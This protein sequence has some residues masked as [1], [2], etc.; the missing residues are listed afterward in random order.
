MTDAEPKG[1]LAA[2]LS[3]FGIALGG[4]AEVGVDLPYRQ[5]DDF[6]SAAE[7]S[8]YRV[9]L[10]AAG[11]RA[12]VCPKVNLADVF[13]VVR[14]NEN[15]GFRNKIDRKHVDFL[16]CAPA[17]MKPLCG[18][19]LDDSSH[20]RPDRQDRDEFVDQ[21]FEVAGLPLV[22]VP[23]KAAYSPAGLLAMIEP[24]LN[25]GSVARLPLP[26][27]QPSGSP[28]CPKCGVPMVERVAKKGQNACQSFFGCPNY[29]KCR[30]IVQSV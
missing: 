15:Q 20:A 10:N 23:A 22:R 16:L 18:I 14:P 29:P 27:N 8:F 19:E 28:I 3:L 26:A 2:I 21:V 9:L 11:N 25:G 30:E 24:H 5:R 1:C 6:L 4:P 17:T 7:L 13:F 12:V